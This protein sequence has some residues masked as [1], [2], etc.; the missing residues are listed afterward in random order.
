MFDQFSDVKV[1]LFEELVK[2][3]LSIADVLASYGVSITGGLP[4]SGPTTT[5]DELYK[6]LKRNTVEIRGC[7]HYPGIRDRII[8]RQ[9]LSEQSSSPISASTLYQLDI[10]A[11]SILQ[12]SFVS[13]NQIA[14]ELLDC[15]LGLYGYLT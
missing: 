15:D 1:L 7:G 5:T 6:T 9:L 10:K 14:G 8:A 2:N 12:D 11:E 13:E 4:H 3:K